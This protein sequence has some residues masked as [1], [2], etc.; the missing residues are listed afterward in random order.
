MVQASK[1]T[2]PLTPRAF[3][4]WL[5]AGEKGD[6]T[7]ALTVAL[8]ELIH[9]LKQLRYSGG[10]DKGALVALALIR[11]HGPLRLSEVATQCGLDLSTI[12]RHVR[13]LEDHDLVARTADPADGRAQLVD[14]TGAGS[15]VLVEAMAARTDAIR[16]ATRT[17]PPSDITTLTDLLTRLVD[18]LAAGPSEDA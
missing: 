15:Q 5:P 7:H 13:T 6:S 12:S 9:E 11:A 4:H 8:H 3:A 17:W 10:I 2:R 18:D 1:E 14:A 16:A